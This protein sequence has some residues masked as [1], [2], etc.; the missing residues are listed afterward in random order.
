MLLQMALFHSNVAEQYSGVCVCVC[1]C[2]SG[3]RVCV[4]TCVCVC[5]RAHTPQVLIHSSIDSYLGCVCVLAFVDS[6]SVNIWVHV[7]VLN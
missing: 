2:V 1:V 7:I 6:A 5:A 4:C 3:V